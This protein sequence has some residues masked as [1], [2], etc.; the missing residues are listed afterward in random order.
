MTLARGLASRSARA[1]PMRAGPSRSARA[2][3]SGC[4]DLP[5]ASGRASRSRSVVT[6]LSGAVLVLGALAG[7]GGSGQ[8]PDAVAP[9]RAVTSPGPGAAS[10]P[11]A[12]TASPD[13]DPQ[14]AAARTLA[15]VAELPLDVRIGQTMLVTTYDLARVAGWLRDGLIAGV[16]ANGRMTEQSGAAYRDATTGLRYGALLASDEEGGQVQRYAALIDTIPSARA[17]AATLTPREVRRLYRRLGTDLATW[18]VEPGPGSRGRCGVR[19]GDRLARLL[20][21]SGCRRQLR[22]GGRPGLG[23]RRPDTGR[24]ALPRARQHVRRLTRR[25]RRRSRHRPAAS[26]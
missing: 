7:C 22:P 23:R 25:T 12:P 18:G 17:Q 19:A 26:Q 2:P 6:G 9:P 11:S 10:T 24:Q 4:H 8:R 5:V 20:G 3:V 16:L 21:G 13:A 14:A 15:C 1:R